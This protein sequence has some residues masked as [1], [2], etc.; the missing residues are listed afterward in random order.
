MYRLTKRLKFEAAHF[1]PDYPGKCARMHGHTYM[2]DVEVSGEDLDA[3]GI[4]LD[5]GQLKQLEE[6]LPDHSVLNESLP[7][8]RSTAEGLARHFYQQFKARLPMVT[9]VTLHEGPNSWCRFEES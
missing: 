4:L 2:V 5:F 7:G 1:I 8:I 9:A 3:L 6:L